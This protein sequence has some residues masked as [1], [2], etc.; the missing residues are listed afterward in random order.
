MKY[1]NLPLL[2]LLFYSS[3][4][5][6]ETVKK[7][8]YL[9]GNL[10]LKYEVLK[11]NKKIRHGK[12]YIYKDSVL[13]ADGRYENDQRAGRWIFFSSDKKMEQI[14]DYSTKTLKV[15]KPAS[16]VSYDIP[17]KVGDTVQ[18]PALIGGLGTGIPSFMEQFLGSFGHPRFNINC[19]LYFIFQLDENGTLNKC[20]YQLKSSDYNNAGTMNFSKMP[21][22]ALVFSPA[23]VNGKPVASTLIYK[24]K[25]FTRTST[26]ISSVTTTR[27]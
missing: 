16:T 18:H 25:Y 1:L 13:L 24:T 5:C 20:S 17:A 15:N 9:F 23:F 7:K 2:L 19:D 11:D 3:S 27:Y 8:K 21:A 14:Y 4:F 22:E 26:V 10:V 12:A 6:Q